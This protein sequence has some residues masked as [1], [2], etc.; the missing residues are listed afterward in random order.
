M[1]KYYT[2]DLHIGHANIISYCNRPFDSVD[3]MNAALIER[4]NATVGPFDD[5]WV[6]GD[7]AMGRI[8]ETLPMI[9]SLNGVKTLLPGNH[10]RCWLGHKKRGDWLRRYHEA[11]F[12]YIIDRD[13]V[14]GFL[15]KRCV[16][17]S[18][19]PYQGDSHDEDRYEDHR[20][21]DHGLPL[22]HGHVH[23]KWTV[24][25]RMINVGVDVRGFAPVSE[26][27]LR[28]ELLTL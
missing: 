26:D 14:E 27:E 16:L 24:K 15:G 8:D 4:W 12:D 13:V 18:H 11:G 10:D 17:V 19:F 21:T 23:D 25:G 28:E 2:S 5:V 20:P 1:T 6:L 9:S 7:V 22:L 3:E